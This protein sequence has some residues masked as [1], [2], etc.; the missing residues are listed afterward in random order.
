MNE[1]HI[2]IA[3]QVRRTEAQPR[4]HCGQQRNERRHAR[5]ALKS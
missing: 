2:S 1:F 4:A 3:P 5:D